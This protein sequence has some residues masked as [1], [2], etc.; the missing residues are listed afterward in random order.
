MSDLFLSSNKI[1]EVVGTAVFCDLSKIGSLEEIPEFPIRTGKEVAHSGLLG[2][3]L[4][5]FILY[6]ETTRGY[7]Q[8]WLYRGYDGKYTIMRSIAEE[9]IFVTG[10]SL[11]AQRSDFLPLS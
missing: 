1:R 6:D 10:E 3:S 5:Q 7:Y 11:P 8:L 4:V 2:F 9:V